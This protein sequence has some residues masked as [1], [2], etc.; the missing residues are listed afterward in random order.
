MQQD[1]AD[2]VFLMT[3]ATGGIGKEACRAFAEHG[4]TLVIVGRSP[5]KTERVRNQL[6]QASGNDRIEVLIADLSRIAEVERVAADFRAGHD[7]LDVLVNNAGA[8]FTT[9]QESA[10]GFELTFALNHLAYFV[11]TRALWELLETTPGARVV[12]TASGAHTAGVIDLDDIA[13]ARK[14]YSGWRAYSASKLANILFTREL[15][16]RLDGKGIANCIHPGW[17]ATGFALNNAG[18]LPRFFKLLAAVFAR[19]PAKGAETLIWAATSPEA[20]HLNGE[21]LQDCKVARTSP[22]A[23]NDKL[24]AALWELSDRL[25]AEVDAKRDDDR[26]QEGRCSRGLWGLGSH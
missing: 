23:K 25:V 26:D 21:Y 7:R 6:V 20:V 10:D 24:A 18:A 19:T 2:K 16:R 17:V 4:A 11:L 1:L 9:R 8:L 5:E 22:L 15:A 12:N 14:G 13:Y 3:G